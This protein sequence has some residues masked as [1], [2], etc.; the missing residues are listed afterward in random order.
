MVYC[1]KALELIS[2]LD[3]DEL[4][5]NIWDSLGYAHHNLGHHEQ[6]I[7]CYQHAVKLLLETGQ[8]HERAGTLN[9]LGD[10]HHAAGDDKAAHDTWTQAQRIFDDLR[11]SDADR[12][13]EKLKALPE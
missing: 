10:T 2:G 4:E 6:A 8:R 7:E 11:H 5:G 12:I 13:R 3:Q 1:R 9:R